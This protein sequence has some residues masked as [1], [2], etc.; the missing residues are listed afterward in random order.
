MATTGYV[1]SKLEVPIGI[2][3]ND[4]DQFLHVFAIVVGL[5]TRLIHSISLHVVTQYQEVFLGFYR[6][7]IKLG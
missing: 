1:A 3:L 2:A 6:T 7:G 5:F 4:L